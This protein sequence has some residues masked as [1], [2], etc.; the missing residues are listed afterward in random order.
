[1][2]AASV[3]P[4]AEAALASVA[5]RCLCEAAQLSDAA[6]LLATAELL[7]G[8]LLSTAGVKPS[9][10]ECLDIA[11]L[12]TPPLL[13]MPVMV[14]SADAS[15][16]EGCLDKIPRLPAGPE[17]DMPGTRTSLDTCLDTAFEFALLLS[18]RPGILTPAS[19]SVHEG[20]LDRR[21]RRLAAL[22]CDAAEVAVASANQSTPE[23]GLEDSPRAVPDRP[24]GP[25]TTHI[26]SI[27]LEQT[28]LDEPFDD[29]ACNICKGMLHVV[30]ID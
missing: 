19:T 22:L 1:M 8:F 16:P 4:S 25:T 10:D 11:P 20:C 21:P 15:M 18:E 29:G 13:N 12:S 7:Y 6:G 5:D 24:A 28:L 2:L 3:I 9:A 26:A 14:A 27:V 23:P 30:E 17:L